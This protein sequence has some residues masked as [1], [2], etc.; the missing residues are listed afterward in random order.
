MKKMIIATMATGLVASMASA[1]VAVTADIASAYVFRGITVVDDLVVQPGIEVGDFGL[2]EEYGAISLGVWG[3]TAPFE[4]TYNNL[5][6]TDWY[7]SYALPTIISNLD[8]SVTFTEYQYTLAPGEQELGFGAAYA[9]ADAVSVGGSVNFMVDDENTATEDQVYFDFFADYSLEL[10]DKTSANVSGL[11]GFM[12]QGDGN[13]TAGLDDGF[14]QAEVSGALSHALNDMWS[15]GASL[16]WITQ[17]DDNVL[18]DNTAA[19]N[20]GNGHDRH[21]VAMFSIGCEM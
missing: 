15:I 19:G 10:S 12:I 2:P 20:F 14:N 18:P 17:L 7:L 5:H 11:I 9:L 4:D 21:L 6:E 16:T 13:D 8:L 1:E 3:S